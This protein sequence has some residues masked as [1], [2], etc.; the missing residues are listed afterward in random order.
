LSGS[1]FNLHT[2]IVLKESLIE[3]GVLVEHQPFNREN[4]KRGF[5]IFKIL[6]STQL[7][8]CWYNFVK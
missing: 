1:I 6:T 4:N 3:G 2:I 7:F 8:L 5:D